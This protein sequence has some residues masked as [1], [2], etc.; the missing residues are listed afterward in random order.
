[1]VNPKTLQ[2]LAFGRFSVAHSMV[3]SWNTLAEWFEVIWNV[4]FT[5]GHKV[6]PRFHPGMQEGLKAVR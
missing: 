3:T 4:G 6:L 5:P 1:M 2:S